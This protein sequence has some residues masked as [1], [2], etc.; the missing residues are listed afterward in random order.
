MA[1]ASRIAVDR[2]ND[3]FKVYITGDSLGEFLERVVDPLDHRRGKIQKL[4]DRGRRNNR[5]HD[6]LPTGVAE[7]LV[8]LLDDA[9]MSYNG[10]F[11]RHLK[12]GNGITKPTTA[13]LLDQIED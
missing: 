6:V 12:S 13:R 1:I 9:G 5:S 4:V 7:M 10:Y 2:S 3:S 8:Q 11:S